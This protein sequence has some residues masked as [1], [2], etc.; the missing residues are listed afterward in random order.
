M[1]NR[2]A[3]EFPTVRWHAAVP[4]GIDHDLV[5]TA[6]VR[7]RHLQGAAIRR[8]ARSVLTTVAG[9]LA[10]LIRGGAY[11]TAKRTPERSCGGAGR[12]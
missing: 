12:A 9:A 2:L 8:G 3:H 7:G 11:R 1:S 6:L 10:V 5:R 4:R